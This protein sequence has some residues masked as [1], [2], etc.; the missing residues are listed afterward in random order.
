[1]IKY[2]STLTDTLHDNEYDAQKAEDEYIEKYFEELSLKAAKKRRK[3]KHLNDTTDV[4]NAYRI[5][6]W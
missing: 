5:T 2:Y 6:I 1:M 3:L 4:S